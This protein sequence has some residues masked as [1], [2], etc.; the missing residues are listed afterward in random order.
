M[1]GHAC[2]FVLGAVGFLCGVWGLLQMFNSISARLLQGVEGVVKMQRSIS[3]SIRGPFNFV[4]NERC[5]PVDRFNDV[6]NLEPS[7]GKVLHKFGSSAQDEVNRA[8]AAA[9]EAYQS[10]SKVNRSF[11]RYLL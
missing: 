5:E 4:R 2:C 7:T 6:D 8:I 11:S 10:W 3:T 9:K 1:S